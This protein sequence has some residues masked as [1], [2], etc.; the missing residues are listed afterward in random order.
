MRRSMIQAD[1]SP[2]STD[3]P[4]SDRLSYT[5]WRN[6]SVMSARS[7]TN[8]QVE[9][10]PSY[11]LS[12]YQAEVIPRQRKFDAAPRDALPW[13]GPEHVGTA[14]V[15]AYSPL[16][17]S[18]KVGGHSHCTG[19]A[20]L[21]HPASSVSVRATSPYRSSPAWSGSIRGPWAEDPYEQQAENRE[22]GADAT[23]AVQLRTGGRSALDVTTMLPALTMLPPHSKRTLTSGQQWTADPFH[24]G[25]QLVAG[26]QHLAVDDTRAEQQSLEDEARAARY[27]LGKALSERSERLPSR[28]GRETVSEARLVHAMAQ[29][30]VHV[31]RP[32]SRSPAGSPPHP[33]HSK[34]SIR[35]EAREAN[36]WKSYKEYAG[37]CTARQTPGTALPEMYGTYRV[38]GPVRS[39]ISTGR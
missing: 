16:K 3:G 20:G 12:A 28:T 2:E 19:T 39:I 7:M 5:L 27:W 31:P 9:R 24:L 26:M 1:S 34:E 17:V 21:V 14:Y 32:P 10:P 35:C 25:K 29:P 30:R 13:P 33:R 11:L 6:G 37:A 4:F 22:G 23:L 36:T 18:R 38:A 15:P 8:S